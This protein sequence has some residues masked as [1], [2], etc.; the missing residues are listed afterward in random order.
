MY[1][2]IERRTVANFTHLNTPSHSEAYRSDSAQIRLR[3]ERTPPT[4]RLQIGKVYLHLRRLQSGLKRELKAVSLLPC[5]E[6][7]EIESEYRERPVAAHIQDPSLMWRQVQA[8][9]EFGRHKPNRATPTLHTAHGS[10]E[11]VKRTLPM[12]GSL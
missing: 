9:I 6:I 1:F 8:V 3:S 12:Y 11:D 10:L 2:E 4:H 5:S 7:L